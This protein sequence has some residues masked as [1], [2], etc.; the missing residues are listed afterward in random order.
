[1]IPMRIEFRRNSP[2]F[3]EVDVEALIGDGGDVTVTITKT[4]D[5]GSGIEE[6]GDVVVAGL[7]AGPAWALAQY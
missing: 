7:S 2:P 3:R 4:V 5:E 1:M 6:P